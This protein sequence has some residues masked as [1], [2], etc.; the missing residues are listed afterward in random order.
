MLSFVFAT[1]FSFGENRNLRV[2]SLN[3]KPT[4][5]DVLTEGQALL[6]TLDMFDIRTMNFQSSPNHA[7]WFKSCQ[8]FFVRL[9]KPML[10]MVY[11]TP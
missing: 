6:R 10:Q 2:T 7:S 4:D 8:G 1:C 3:Q 9:V 11:H 5:Q